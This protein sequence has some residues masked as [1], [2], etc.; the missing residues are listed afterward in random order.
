MVQEAGSS[1]TR[2]PRSQ[3]CMLL[4]DDGEADGWHVPGANTGESRG[5]AKPPSSNFPFLQDSMS[6]FM[7]APSV[8]PHEL[9]L[10][11]LLMGSQ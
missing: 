11:Q 3:A 8:D 4:C 5:S 9:P 10:A 1:K 7:Q 6:S 2:N